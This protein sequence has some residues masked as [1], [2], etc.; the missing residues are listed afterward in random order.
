VVTDTYLRE[1]FTAASRAKGQRSGD[2]PTD[3]YLNGVAKLA[4]A[5]TTVEQAFDALGRIEGD[6]GRLMVD[7]RGVEAR[8]C[9]A[10]RDLLTRIDDDLVIWSRASRRVNGVASPRRAPE[11]TEAEGENDEPNVSDDFGAADGD[12][13]EAAE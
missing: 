1:E 10:W 7:V 4:A 3:R 12:V 6:D 8:D 5:M 13:L 2:S 9:A 11:P